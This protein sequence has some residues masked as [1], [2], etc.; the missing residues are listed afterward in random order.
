MNYLQENQ[1]HMNTSNSRWFNLFFFKGSRRMLLLLLGCLIGSA[2]LG[3]YTPKLIAALSTNYDHKPAFFSALFDLF[4]NF[5]LVYVNRVLYQLAVNKYVRMLIQYARVQTY[6]RWLGSSE[7]LSDKYPQGEILSRIMSDTDSIKDLITSGSFGLFIDLCFV[8]SCLVGFIQLD[9]F[10]G[11]FITIS[12]VV[13]TVALIWAS[14]LMRD[15]FIKVRAMYAKVNRVTANVI[16]GFSQIFYQ[17]HG[18]YASKTCDVVFAD[19]LDKQNKANTMDAAYYACA[20]S[21]YPILLALMIFVIPVSGVREAALL[22][23][24]VDL[25]QR[26]ISPIKEISGKIANIQRA[27]TGIER[28]TA[29][30][31]DMP[32]VTISKPVDGNT[33]HLV[34]MNVDIENFSYQV[35][36]N[37]G[38]RSNF[39]LKN[40][41]FKARAG[42]LVGIV[43][44]SGSGKSTLLN[45]LAGNIIAPEANVWLKINTQFG[46]KDISLND[47][48]EYRKEVSIVSQESH[49]FTETLLFN[50]TLKSTFTVSELEAFI[51][52][53]DIFLERIPYLKMLKIGIHDVIQPHKLSLGQR[54]LLAGVRACYLKK[55]VVF[56]DE[57]SSALDSDLE[58]ALRN[59]ILLIQQNSL[60]FI[61]AHRIETI[62]NSTNI[63]VMQNGQIIDSGIHKDLLNSSKVYKE[64]IKELSHN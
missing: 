27:A 39:S 19:Y 62:V 14:Q 16:G 4:V 46:I 33:T 53:W 18:N 37:Q 57:I 60:T 21:L 12:E 43:G 3:V 24:I 1:K 50:I 15:I 63:L 40:I 28:I 41:H 36:A 34:E 59:C 11:S 42:N 31:R 56:I 32:E 10:T 35:K 7:A 45:I 23:A 5:T 64:F 2:W 54:Q 38:A 52:E 55:N 44:L 22:F 17:D 58:L 61:V 49:I 13:A 29:F 25:I 48:D 6:Q 26:S 20:E 47:I 30:L 9:L 8:L 51:K